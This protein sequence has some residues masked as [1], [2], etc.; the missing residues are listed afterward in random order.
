MP[1]FDIVSELEIFEVNHAVQNTQKEIAT[2]FDF[3]GQDVSIELNEKNK[4]I[5]ISTES[6][7]Q[8]EQVYSMLENHFFKRKVDI[9]ALDPQKMTASGKNVIQVIKLKDGLDSDT[10]KKINKAIKES[11]VKVQSSIQGDKIRVTDKKRDTLQ[12]TM[13][14][15]KEQQFGVPLQFNNFKD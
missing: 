3:R 8:C 12:Q 2:R 15:L 13:A 10:A 11:G 14:F 4:E 7:F 1:S 9:Q 5:K 6:D